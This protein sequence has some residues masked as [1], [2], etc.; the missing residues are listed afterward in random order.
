MTKEL[1]EEEM[2]RALFGSSPA[3]SHSADTTDEALGLPKRPPAA[4][5]PS[6]AA[7][8]AFKLR[9]TL[10]VTNVFEGAVEVVHFD[11]NTLSKL[12][13]EIDAKKKYKKKYKYIE[14]VSILPL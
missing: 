8:S 12:A 11:T 9:V 5:K 10:N 14:V 3:S 4:S 1:T 6:S 7:K 2:R 13:A